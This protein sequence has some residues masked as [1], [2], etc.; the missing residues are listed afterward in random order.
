MMTIRRFSFQP[1]PRHLIAT[2]VLAGITLQV[3][4]ADG[5]VEQVK[6]RA[7]AH[8]GFDRATLQPA[9]RDA[10][11]AEVGKMTGVT[12]QNVVAVGHTDNIGTVEYN[13][14]LSAR[15]A[16]VVKTYL[17][18]KGLDGQMIET[19]AR[20]EAGPVASNATDAGRA[21]NRRTEIEFQGVRAAPVA[22][23][24]P[25]APVAPAAPVAQ[26]SAPAR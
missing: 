24:A 22:S 7:V 26:P 9:D 25:V 20:A 19:E 2:A 18:G 12:W 3:R 5:P 11:L 23:T 4:A 8:F 14:G 15:R 13:R 1:T 6:V 21:E 10:L 16:Q 17:I